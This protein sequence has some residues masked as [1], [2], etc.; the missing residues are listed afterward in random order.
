MSELCVFC[1]EWSRG[2][3]T[4]AETELRRARW[5]LYPVT[6]GHVERTP[7]RHVQYIEQLSD[8]EDATLLRF[9]RWVM[10]TIR[11]TDLEQLYRT[12]LEAADDTNRSLQQGALAS[13]AL[14]A[15][16]PNAFNFGLNDGPEAG[17]SVPHFHLHLMPRWQGDMKNPRGGV[18][19]IFPNDS[20]KELR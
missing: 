2:D 13:L 17:Q 12:M 6:P 9:A 5:D 7:K 15:G 18:R 16:E 20:Y 3:N 4:F 8:E 1:D 10:Q 14:R 19:N 11:E